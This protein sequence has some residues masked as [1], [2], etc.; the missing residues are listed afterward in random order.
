MKKMLI[1]AIAIVIALSATGCKNNQYTA[2]GKCNGDTII[3]DDGNVWECENDIKGEWTDVIIR[4]D[5]NGTKDDITDD[6]ILS[7]NYKEYI[8]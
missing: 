6:I 8:K 2:E 4:F 5:D 7:V 3:T 1:T